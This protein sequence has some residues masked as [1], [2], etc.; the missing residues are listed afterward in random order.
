M[1]ESNSHD[2]QVCASRIQ[3]GAS[4]LASHGLSQKDDGSDYLGKA[5]AS[6]AIDQEK[7]ATDQ[8]ASQLM[9]FMRLIQ[10]T[11]QEFQAVDAQLRSQILEQLKGSPTPY[12]S[13]FIPRAGLF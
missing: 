9:E 12:S 6:S 2:A 13:N 4:Q 10:Q 5:S 11:N 8:L 7:L 3:Q 1:I